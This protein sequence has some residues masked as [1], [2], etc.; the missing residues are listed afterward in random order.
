MIVF[1]NARITLGLHVTS[2]RSDGYHNIESLML[3]VAL[4]DALEVIEAPDGCMR[5]TTSGLT[6]P[7]NGRPNLC[8]QAWYLL[9]A[10][11]GSCQKK[12]D[13]STIRPV[14]IHLYK[15]IPAGAG[16]AGGSADAAFMLSLIST[17]F[18]LDMSPEDLLNAAARLGS[19]CPFFIQNKPMMA[20]GRGDRLQPMPLPWI[21]NYYVIIA[22]P[23]IHINTAEAY[24]AITPANKRAPLQ[25][26]LQAPVAQWQSN[27][28]NDFENIM[29]K[30]Y[31]ELA[32]LKNAFL[33]TGAIYASLS[34]SGSAIYGLFETPETFEA[35]KKRFP[36][37][38]VCQADPIITD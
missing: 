30:K 25:D 37:Y 12:T 13:G 8:E 14:H 16:L 21:K 6:I 2:R 22:V 23:P 20:T 11:T 27:V 5:F 9:D 31:T 24:A 3:P 15:G 10:I 4:H 36:E 38:L 32:G 18:E 34:G 26:L 17:I 1:P 28:R 33:D 7:D 35:L 19:D 29:L